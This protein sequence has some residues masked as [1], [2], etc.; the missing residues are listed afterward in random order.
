MEG[1]VR[2]YG[3]KWQNG[4]AICTPLMVVSS[5]VGVWFHLWHSGG[6][7]FSLLSYPQLDW[8]MIYFVYAYWI[9]NGN[10]GVVFYFI[11]KECTFDVV[12]IFVLH[13][14]MYWWGIDYALNFLKYIY[15]ITK[16]EFP[17]KLFSMSHFSMLS[18]LW[19]S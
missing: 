1:I 5:I 14:F 17:Y 13:W 9:G 19:R 12:G 8:I 7:T 6:Y 11:F 15:R 18:T 2:L 3:E 4:L 16:L 10:Y